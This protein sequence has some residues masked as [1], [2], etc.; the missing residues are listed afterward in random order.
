MSI[1]K[2][3]KSSA[4]RSATDRRRHK[5]KIEKA[6]KEGI[7]DI[8]AEES[9]IGQNGKK[10]IKI[11]VRGIKE[12]QFI[13]GKNNKKVGSAQG[14]DI[15]KG[16]KIGKGQKKP[17]QGQSD[18]PGN[19]AGEEFYE[20]D[21][22]LDELAKYLFDDL[23]LPEL[24]K[25]S[26]PN[27]YSETF[28]RKGYRK[29][30][31]RP[32]LSKKE[33]LKRKIRRKKAAILNGTYEVES[34]ERF[35][36]H[37]DDLKYKHIEITQKSVT[38]ATIF[39]IMDT[40]GSMSKTKKFKAR[41]FFFLLYQFIR[42]RYDKTE[43]VFISHTTEA[44]ETNE[45]EFFERGSSGGTHLSSGLSKALEIIDKR[46]PT[47]SWNIYAFHCS[48][49]DNW[50]EDND[51]AV[52][53]TIKLRDVSQLYSYIEITDGRKGSAGWGEPMSSIYKNLQNKSFKI[54][55]IDNKED[56]WPQF[57]KLFGNYKNE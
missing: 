23:N 36:F 37:K 41:S 3:H 16:Q 32:R 4:D 8:V 56:I 20:V 53:L 13:Y 15:T 1:F 9:I 30:G 12:F 7:H 17:S 6:I 34:G 44:K 50:S 45:K 39:F 24:E 38:N 21:I 5:E 48:D 26:F 33:T 43:I 47:N 19:A 42:Y 35:P 57:R 52:N 2:E 18:K 51:K 49:G 14:K 54:V 40:S 25:K 22:S 55:E 46:Y 11:P 29:E 31:I 10:R 28:K 27:I